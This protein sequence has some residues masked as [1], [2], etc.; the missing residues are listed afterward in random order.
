MQSTRIRRSAP[1]KKGA[2]GGISRIWMGQWDRAEAEVDRLI[3]KVRELTKA[4]QVA[5]DAV[6]AKDYTITKL[7][8]QI[9]DLQAKLKGAL[10][11]SP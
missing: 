8:M 10:Q 11:D 6:K 1:F 2:W 4:Q 9:A 7:N 5:Q 3:Q